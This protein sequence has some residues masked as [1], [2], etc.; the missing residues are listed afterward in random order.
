MS[1]LTA[2]VLNFPVL[3]SSTAIVQVELGPWNAWKF[4]C[5][6]IFSS[7]V[8]TLQDVDSL[9]GNIFHLGTMRKKI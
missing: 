1:L 5:L 4:S 6:T 8:L 2:P 3:F 9:M 7:S